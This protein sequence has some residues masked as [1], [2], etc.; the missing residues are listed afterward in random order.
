M[1]RNP[2]VPD[3][4]RIVAAWTLAVMAWTGACNDEAPVTGP[5]D[6][7]SPLIVS[8]PA[9]SVALPGGGFAVVL[10][11]AGRDSLSLAAEGAAFA[12]VAYISLP[13]GTIPSGTDATIRNARTGRTVIAQIVTGG[14]DPVGLEA[15]ES[16]LV[17][18]EVRRADTQT[19]LRFVHKVPA[20]RRPKVV[21]TNPPGGKRDVALNS[22]ISIIFSE[23][24]DDR[25][26]VAVP[27]RLLRGTTPVSGRLEFEDVDHV[28]AAFVPNE[29]LAS[30]TD[31]QVVINQDVYDLDGDALEEPLT[32]EF[33]TTAVAPP[34]TR[35][36][37]TVEPTTTLAGTP[38]TP[39]VRVAAEDE[40]GNVVPGFAGVVTI[41]LSTNSGGATLRGTTS[42]ELVNG[43]ATFT[44]LV[45]D[46]AGTGY[47]LEAAIQALSLT[48]ISSAFDVTALSGDVAYFNAFEASVGSEWSHSQ[49]S[50]V[51]DASRAGP[52][53]LGDFGC[54]DYE[55]TT[56]SQADNCR[57]ADL[58]TLTLSALPEHAQLTITFDLYVISSWDGN[59]GLWEGD[60][61]IAPDVF[62]LSVA[63]G[64]TLLNA[65][66]AVHPSRLYQSYPDAYPSD[67]TTPPNNAQNTGALEII[68]GDFVVYRLTFTFPHSE[69]SVVFRFTAPSLQWLDDEWWGLEDRKSVV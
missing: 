3:R 49:R 2:I 35:L 64:P 62:N 6:A 11:S 63:G 54:T 59:P 52:G 16:D 38:I 23:P 36:R 66:F 40:L 24:I 67:G 68:Y 39:A 26:L 61:G 58:V 19:P 55:E 30:G 48:A 69:P 25:T 4:L 46:K 9:L 37:F 57:A 15:L 42:A 43:I 47:R 27:V 22:R 56:P 20:N 21:R 1:L 60:E 32:A 65:S 29:P 50:S 17:E 7:I 34:P 12:R 53:Y 41:A 28:I 45:V 31:Y 51:P 44:G 8:D 14:L 5:D 33:T 13:S 10:A 18:L